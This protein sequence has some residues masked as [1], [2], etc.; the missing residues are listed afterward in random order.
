MTGKARLGTR[1][2]AFFAVAGGLAYAAALVVALLTGCS[3]TLE[4]AVTLRVARAPETPRDASVTIDEQYV[5]PLGLVAARGVRLPVGRHRV[6]IEKPG[7]F[8]YDELVTADRDDIALE[9]RLDR[10][11]D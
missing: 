8:P 7:Y 6:T 9:V 10:V 11:P 4:G 5:G 2:T 3:P 1:V